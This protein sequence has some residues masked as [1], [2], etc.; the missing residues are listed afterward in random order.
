VSEDEIIKKIRDVRYVNNLHW[1]KLLQIALK[2]APIETKKVLQAI[3]D[4]DRV[5]SG[6]LAEL[7]K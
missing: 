4:N 6:L 1:M 7:A 2:H 3:N 5:V